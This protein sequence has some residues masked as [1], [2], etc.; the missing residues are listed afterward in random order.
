[1]RT[2]MRALMKEEILTQA[3]NITVLRV[4]GGV[5]PRFETSRMRGKIQHQLQTGVLSQNG[6]RNTHPSLIALFL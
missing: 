1:M 5:R 3:G 6:L 2:R 4:T